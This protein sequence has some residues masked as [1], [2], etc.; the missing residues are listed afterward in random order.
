VAQAQALGK[1]SGA[2]PRWAPE[3]LAKAALRKSL[4]DLHATRSARSCWRRREDQQEAL[5]LFDARIAAENPRRSNRC[6]PAALQSKQAHTREAQKMSGEARATLAGAVGVS[7]HALDAARISL[8]VWTPLPPHPNE[9]TLRR[10]ALLRRSDVLAALA[11]YAAT[12]AALRL[13]IAKQYPD[14]HL[15]PGYSYDQG[16][17]KWT[18]GFSATLPI[19]DQNRGRCRGPRQAPRIR[20]EF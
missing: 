5:K 1:R 7:V 10:A 13:E 14:V 15:G 9:R 4:M 18:I 6:R 16:Q 8:Q 2:E 3:W 11:E 20:G 19:F 17:D 12:E